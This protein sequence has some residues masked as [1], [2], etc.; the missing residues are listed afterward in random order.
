MVYSFLKLTDG[1]VEEGRLWFFLEH[2]I[3]FL[4]TAYLTIV[5][6]KE[7]I[8]RQGDLYQIVN[9]LSTFAISLN[10]FTKVVITLFYLKE[11]RQLFD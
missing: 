4:L 5:S 3:R 8:L 7:L 6:G 11:I 2:A 9:S 1:K 10:I